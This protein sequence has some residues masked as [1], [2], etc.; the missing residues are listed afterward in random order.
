MQPEQMLARYSVDSAK[1]S[2]PGQLAYSFLEK[3][4]RVSSFLSE[5]IPHTLVTHMIHP[6]SSAG[7]VTKDSILLF[8]TRQP[9]SE[10]VS[11]WEAHTLTQTTVKQETPFP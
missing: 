11:V 4:L 6:R 9:H 7:A 10:W 2:Y 3:H 8:K 5:F 1:E